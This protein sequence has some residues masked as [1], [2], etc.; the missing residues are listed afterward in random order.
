MCNKRP[1]RPYMLQTEALLKSRPRLGERL[2]GPPGGGDSPAG[3]TFGFLMSAFPT[4]PEM[5]IVMYGGR[6]IMDNHLFWTLMRVIPSEI[7]YI[8]GIHF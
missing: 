8:K 1:F 5:S 3:A 6:I 2:R 4:E 7:N